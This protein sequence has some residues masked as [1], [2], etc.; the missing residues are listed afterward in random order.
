MPVPM[1][2]KEELN[3]WAPH[4]RA[5]YAEALLNGER[6]LREAGILDSQLALAHFM[7]QVG[8][9]TDGLTIVRESMNYGSTT[10]IKQVW[11]SRASRVTPDLVHNEKALA[12]WAYNGRMG[13]RPGTDDGFNFRG[14]GYIQT[15]GREPCERYCASLG[16]PMSDTVLGDPF[17]TLR[18]ACF[19]W[20]ESGCKRYAEA[21]DLLSVSK[22]INT[23]NA[24]SGV[25]P[26]GMSDR[27]VWF[28]RAWNIWGDNRKPLGQASSVTAQ[29]L[30][31]AGSETVSHGEAVQKIGAAGAVA[32]AV[33]GLHDKFD[34]PIGAADIPHD[35]PVAA[36]LP[37]VPVPFAPPVDAVPV[38]NVFDHMSNATA[39]LETAT[40]FAGAIKQMLTGIGVLISDNLWIIG[41][42][43]S[44][45][46]AYY[47]W[48][49]VKRRVLDARLGHNTSRLD[50]VVHAFDPN[51]RT[52]DVSN[53]TGAPVLASG[54]GGG[55]G[56]GGAAGFAGGGGGGSGGAG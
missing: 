36:S 53:S 55:G 29:Q 18:F 30:K 38:P 25:M 34:L 45:V 27:R 13:N 42:L 37:D 26:N 14:G 15:T 40:T 50:Q 2:T 41:A 24:R 46:A 56:G 32:S 7:G 1:I 35:L 51:P 54:G 4:A 48:K 49:I 5:D 52:Q 20:K 47:G 23:G 33:K 19:E 21:N 22:I 31:A 43:L 39:K 9:E 11:P 12:D 6:W 28:S 3:R 17:I 8:A 44:G 10:R 16:I